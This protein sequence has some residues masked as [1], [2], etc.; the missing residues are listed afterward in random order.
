MRF[1]SGKYYRTRCGYKAQVFMLD[2]GE[3]WAL[4]AVQDEDDKWLH[5][6]WDKDTGLTAV[7]RNADIVGEWKEP[8]KPK[9][10][11]PALLKDDRYTE[12]SAY[13]YESEEHAREVLGDCFRYWP[14]VPNKDGFYE[15]PSDET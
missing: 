2:N 5:E 9:L 13:L 8:P 7:N 15:V 12:L 3:G 1:E 11:A 6:S 14:A 4:G 10:M